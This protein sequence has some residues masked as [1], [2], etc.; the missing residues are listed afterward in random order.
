M[1]NHSLAIHRCK[2]RLT[3][4]DLP[5]SLNQIAK[6]HIEVSDIIFDNSL[7]CCFYVNYR[8]Y[9]KLKD[10]LIKRG[11]MVKLQN[12][13]IFRTFWK[14]VF[15]H[16][17]F[18]FLFSVFIVLGNVLPGYILFIEI[19]GNQKI[20]AAQIEAAA[21]QCGLS[22]GSARSSI[23]SEKIKNELI[24]RM[25]EL[26]WIG[27]NTRGCRAMITVAEKISDSE[28]SNGYPGNVVAGISGQ[29]ASCTVSSGSLLCVPGDYVTAGQRLISGNTDVG[30]TVLSGKAEGEIFAYTQRP[31]SAAVPAAVRWI[32]SERSVHR[33][34]SLIIPNCKIKL[35]FSSGILGADCGR[36]YKQ[37]YICLPGGFTLPYGIESETVTV[38]CPEPGELTPDEAADAMLGVSRLAVNRDMLAGKILSEKTIVSSTKD[39]Y[40][41]EGSFSCYEM[42]GRLQVQEIEDSYEYN[43]RENS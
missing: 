1:D 41:L 13:G 7:E 30:R 37:Y 2:V 31:L 23:R 14:K 5:G 36:M 18:L 35:Y 3:S 15:K 9:L 22:V 24:A 21:A 11:D 12:Y 34:Y 8:D 20:T 40:D 17:V 38:Y 26:K 19:N 43:H 10:C 39:R 25:P 4:A 32:T 29:V 33:R 6:M 16:P 42:I 27:I 28:T